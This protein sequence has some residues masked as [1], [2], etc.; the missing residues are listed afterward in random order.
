[1]FSPQFRQEGEKQSLSKTVKR[2]Q[3]TLHLDSGVKTKS[4]VK[5]AIE[6]KKGVVINQRLST[7]S[8]Q[9]K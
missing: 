3:K 1:M 4:T 5:A 9:S 2:S 6:Q 8:G 7:K